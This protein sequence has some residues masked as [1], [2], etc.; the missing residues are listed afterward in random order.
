MKKNVPFWVRNIEGVNDGSGSATSTNDEAKEGA[1]ETSES[2]K[3]SGGATDDADHWKAQARKWEKRAKENQS[4]AEK[5]KEREDAE[6]SELQKAEE[7][8]A[9]A[10]KA[11]TDVESRL[12]RSEIALEFGLSKS[13]ADMFLHGSEEDMRQQAKKLAQL[14]K[15]TGSK[16]SAASDPYQGR[17]SG[18]SSRKDAESW[19]ERLLGSAH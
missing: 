17:E 3:G 16:G 6:K 18:S 9:E 7:R 14:G 8:L 13:D 15:S 1:G 5:L 12:A 4:A 2:G 19:A 11:R 10:V